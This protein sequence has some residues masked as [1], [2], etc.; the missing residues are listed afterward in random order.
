MSFGRCVFRS[1]AFYNENSIYLCYK[2]SYLIEEVNCMKLAPSV[3]ASP[4][5]DKKFYNVDDR[6]GPSFI[7]Y[8]IELREE[9]DLVSDISKDE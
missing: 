6:W 5:W 7:K 9:Q 3:R 4:D 1:A 8:A 2:T